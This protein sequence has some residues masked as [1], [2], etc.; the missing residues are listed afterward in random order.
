MLY[1]HRSWESDRFNAARSIVCGA[2]FSGIAMFVASLFQCRTQHCMWCNLLPILENVLCPRVS[3]PHAALYVVQ[4]RR[5]KKTTS[6]SRCFNAARSIVCGATLLSLCGRKGDGWFQCRTQHCMWCNTVAHSP[7]PAQGE[8]AFWKV[9]NFLP[10]FPYRAAFSPKN[11]GV[12]R[13]VPLCGPELRPNGKW[14][15]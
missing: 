5:W 11:H 7:C 8:R 10:F 13:R 6:P 12:D 4:P 9:V 15:R 14:R 1:S 2:T 3:M